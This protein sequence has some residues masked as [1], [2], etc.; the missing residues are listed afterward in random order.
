MGLLL[1]LQIVW[2][3]LLLAIGSYVAIA[4]FVANSVNSAMDPATLGPL[5]WAF[6][7][8]SLSCLVVSYFLPRKLLRAA[9][10]Q[11]DPATV[12]LEK[13][14]GMAFTP[15]I[16]RMALT[17]SIGIYGLL[18]AMMSHQPSKVLPFAIIAALVMIT[19]MP[20]ERALRTAAQ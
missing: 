16:V 11:E 1:N 8:M 6:A 10:G 20:S 15:W 17:E 14:V 5:E 3:G 12:P 13:L 9:L 19:A 18:A 7:L 2:M 4:Y